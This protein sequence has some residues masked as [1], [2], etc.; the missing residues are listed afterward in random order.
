MST[1]IV[2]VAAGSGTRLGAGLPKALVPVGGTSLL[3][4]CVR[5]ARAVPDVAQVVVV[6]PPTHLAEA[7]AEAG[8]GVDGGRWRAGH[9]CRAD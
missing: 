1:A 5:T 8:A 9:R 7:G 2:V 4:R 3:A 6:A